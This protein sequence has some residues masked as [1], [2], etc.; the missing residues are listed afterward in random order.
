MPPKVWVSLQRGC[1]FRGCGSF[2]ALKSS[3]GCLEQLSGGLGEL[4]RSIFEYSWEL[5][6]VSKGRFWRWWNQFA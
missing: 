4:S 2:G 1:E 6:E 3:Q 5:S